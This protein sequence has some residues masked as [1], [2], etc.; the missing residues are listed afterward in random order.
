[1]KMPTKSELLRLQKQYRTDKRIAEALGGNVTEHLVQY[2][3]RKKGIPRKSF[4]K[5]P[6]AQIRELWERFGDDFRCGRELGLSKAGFYSWRRRYGIKEKPRALKLEQLELRFGSEPKMGR[7]GVFIE[8]YR[9]SA[10]KILMKNAGLEMIEYGQSIEVSPDLIVLD[11]CNMDQFDESE[12]PKEISKR[13]RLV[14]GMKG[15]ISSRI[16]HGIEPADS[17]Y[18]LLQ[19][20][21]VVPSLLIA[22]SG[23]TAGGLSALSSLILGIDQSQTAQVLKTG[24]FTMKVPPVVRIALQDRLMRGVTAFDVFA[25]A[26][27][28]LPASVFKN[29]IIEYAGSVVEKM[30]IHER[31]CLCHLTQSFGAACGYTIFDETSRKFITK[32]GYVDFKVWFSDSKAYYHQDY[33]LTLSGLEPQVVHAGNMSLSNRVGD[34]QDVKPIDI[35]FI[36]GPAAGSAEAIKQAA[37]LLKG[38]KINKAVRLFVAPLTEN[39]YLETM[40]R[41]LLIPIVEA[42]GVILPPTSRFED[43]PGFDPEMDATIVATPVDCE[44][45]YPPNCWMTNHLTA[46][47]SAIKG[48]LASHRK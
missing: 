1:M 9:T 13:L 8:Y 39:A 14:T 35:V 30:N 41:R 37:D 16:E 38:Q 5:Y 32:R 26:V 25:Y 33:V 47:A 11:A 4:P 18:S 29:H 20:E 17:C 34:T 19:S 43:I 10:E 28:H 27:S 24:R 40:R 31:I 21:Q 46:A 12:I 2:W 44:G 45:I 7:N 22:Q 3:R 36:G 15:S 23:C 6:E 48:T 42:G